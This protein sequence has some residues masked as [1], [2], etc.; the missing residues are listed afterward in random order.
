MNGRKILSRFAALLTAGLLAAGAGFTVAT[1]A[2]LIVL[3]FLVYMLV[4][5][6]RYDENHLSRKA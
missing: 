1:A 4:R 5:K 2:A 6:N 3:I